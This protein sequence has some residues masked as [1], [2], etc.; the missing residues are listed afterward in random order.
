MAPEVQKCTVV[1]CFYNENDN[2]CHASAIQVGESDC[3]MCDTF[4]SN[5]QHAAPADQAMVGACREAQCEYNK[6]L[7]CSAPGI[8]VG[9]QVTDSG[10]L[11]SAMFPRA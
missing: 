7:S 3:P 6:M 10:F 4:V 5:D 1:Q 11:S 9:W 2:I 8:E